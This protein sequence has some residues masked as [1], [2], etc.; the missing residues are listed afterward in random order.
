M[1]NPEETQDT[2]YTQE[3][4]IEKRYMNSTLLKKEKYLIVY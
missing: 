3:I 4:E 2:E 1:L